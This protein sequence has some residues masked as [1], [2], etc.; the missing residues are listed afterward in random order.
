MSDGDQ[1]EGSDGR[2]K[3]ER[4]GERRG[5]EVGEEGERLAHFCIC[6]R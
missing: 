5:I 2:R 3:Q 6:S 4:D 1:E